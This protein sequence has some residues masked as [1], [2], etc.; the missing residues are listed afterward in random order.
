[1]I[2]KYGVDIVVIT[3]VIATIILVLCYLYIERDW[4]RW[5]ISVTTIVFVALVLNFFRDPQRQTPTEENIIVSPADGTVVLIKEVYEPDYLKSEALQ[6]SVFMSPL[7]VHVNRFP[8]SG[9]VGYFKHIEGEY[10]VA[11]DDKSSERNERTLIGVEKNG[12]KILFK[13]IAGTVARRIIAETKVGDKAEIGKRFG[14]IRFGSRVDVIM[15]KGTS[16]SVQLDDI[17]RA[18]ETILGRLPK[19]YQGTRQ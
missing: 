12:I 14:M 13:Q 5:L 16:I 7:N 17:V 2:T 19:S 6:V 8:I 11:F 1:M 18:G 15:P 3:L 4:L 9:E 10:I